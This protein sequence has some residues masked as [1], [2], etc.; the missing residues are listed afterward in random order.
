MHNF[1]F[2]HEIKKITH[3]TTIV[4]LIAVICAFIAIFLWLLGS[5]L[6]MRSKIPFGNIVFFIPLLAWITDILTIGDSRHRLVVVPLLLIGQVQAIT[7]LRGMKSN[8]LKDLNVESLSSPS[9][10]PSS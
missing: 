10:K 4:T 7:Q 9:Q 5:L 1:T 8:L 3:S 6:L 2:Y